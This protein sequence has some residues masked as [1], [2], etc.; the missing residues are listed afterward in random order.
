M[1]CIYLIR[2]E[3]S[4]RRNHTN[5]QFSFFHGT[6]LNRRSLGSKHN[7]FVNIKRI[8]LILCWMSFWNIQFCKI[9]FIIFNFRSFHHFISHSHKDSFEFF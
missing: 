1:S 4:P 5:R 9:V 7:F 6:S 2:T 3:H 8:L